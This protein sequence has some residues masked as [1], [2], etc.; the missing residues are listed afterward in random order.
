MNETYVY[1]T[2]Q[3]LLKYTKSKLNIP[4]TV[5]HYILTKLDK[6]AAGDDVY[7]AILYPE[8][9]QLLYRRLADGELANF[10][11]YLFQTLLALK[12]NDEKRGK[13]QSRAADK[14]I[15]FCNRSSLRYNSIVKN[16][17]KV[18]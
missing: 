9:E 2:S 6:N 10:S 7:I 18:K 17:Q 8:G 15:S 16:L 13:S 4:I 11:E 5:K 12:K 3:R 1:L 14:V